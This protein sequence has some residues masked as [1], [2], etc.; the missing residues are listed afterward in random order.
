MPGQVSDEIKEYRKDRLM[1]IQQELSYARNI[2][3]IG[4]IISVL[5]EG[6]VETEAELYEGRTEY[7]APEVDGVVSVRGINLKPGDIVPVKI[8]H[9]YEYDLI[10]EVTNEPA[11]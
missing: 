3:K 2:G 9:A 11:Q 1:K 5:I 10:G 4:E 7:D 8:T 6:K